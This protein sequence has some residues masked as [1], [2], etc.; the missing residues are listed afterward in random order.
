MTMILTQNF[1]KNMKYEY[2]NDCVISKKVKAKEIAKLSNNIDLNFS[3][4]HIRIYK[5]DIENYFHCSLAV[6][7]FKDDED[8]V[9]ELDFSE[10]SNGD[11]YN[12]KNE[13]ELN[14]AENL[15]NDFYYDTPLH[16]HSFDTLIKSI[17][18]YFEYKKECERWQLCLWMKIKGTSFNGYAF[19]EDELYKTT[20]T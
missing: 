5:A 2:R 17:K 3:V 9:L 16:D 19:L 11:D 18:C 20:S 4:A 8:Y 7:A 10:K 13:E 14:F 12:N 1:K 6:P 15:D